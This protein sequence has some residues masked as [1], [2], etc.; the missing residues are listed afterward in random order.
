MT[1]RRAWPL[2]AALIL[3]LPLLLLY[4]WQSGVGVKPALPL[5]GSLS[6]QALML[7]PGETD[8][9]STSSDNV[10]VGDTVRAVDGVRLTFTE[11]TIVDLEPGAIVLVQAAT[12]QDGGVALS[13][14]AGRVHVDTNNPRFRLEAPALALTVERASYAVEI[15]ATGASSVTTERGLVTGTSDGEAVAVAPGESLRTGAGQ[16]VKVEPAMPAFVPPPP[17][18]PVPV[19]RPPTPTP[20]SVPPTPTPQIVHVIVSGD[21]LF[22]LALKYDITVDDIVKA[23]NIQNPNNVALGTKLIIP[24]PKK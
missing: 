19:P 12:P 24:A 14:Q 17:P 15:G 8:W 20:T 9:Q 13:Q 10:Y 2:L 22:A 18:T 5:A 21:T 7:H 11:G 4:R 6:G 23:N 3:L 1:S 16:R